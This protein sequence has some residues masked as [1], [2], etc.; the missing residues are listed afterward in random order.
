M[1]LP[2]QLARGFLSY[3]SIWS[4]L[5][6]NGCL[7]FFA[8]SFILYLYLVFWRLL[9]V[10]PGYLGYNLFDNSISF[11]SCLTISRP[12]FDMT[13]VGPVLVPSQLSLCVNGRV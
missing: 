5:F 9:L 7:E 3:Y 13:T 10:V 12:G 2:A 1:L 6:V 11:W 4:K 8:S